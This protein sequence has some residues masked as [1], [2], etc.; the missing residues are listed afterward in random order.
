MEKLLDELSTMTFGRA[1]STAKKHTICVSCGCPAT[2][3][4]DGLS[5]I[6]YLISG[7]CQ[8]CQDKFFE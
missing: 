1:T 8:V 3:F 6:E 5:E 2:K 7:L 4:S